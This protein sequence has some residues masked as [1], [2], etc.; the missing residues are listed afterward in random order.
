MHKL[1]DLILKQSYKDYEIII[2]D[3]GSDDNTLEIASNYPVKVLRIDPDDFSFGRSLNVGCEAAKGDYL[4]FISAHSYPTDNHWLAN[5]IKPFED[6]RIAMVYG[7]QIGDEIT[8][9]SEERDFKNNFGTKSKI[10]VEESFGNNANAAIRRS[11]WESVPF[12]EKLPALEDIDWAHKVQNKGFY[13][14]YKAD[15]VI[16]HIHAETYRQVYRRFRR[17]AI[18]YK[19]IFPDH[20]YNYAKAVLV[21][22]LM[23][24]MDVYYGLSRKKAMRKVFSPFIY[25]F[26]TL[27]ALH[28]GNCQVEKCDKGPKPG[29]A[30]PQKNL[31]VVVSDPGRHQLEEQEMPS[32]AADDVLIRVCY[33]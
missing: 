27:K 16:H 18:A 31:R 10:L 2:V 33:V 26:F 7:R 30:F 29:L 15:A 25:R 4:V 12:D 9:V 17:E 1:L 22:F 5:L 6:P 21:C 20:D 3:S 19:M 32:L 14:Y 8:K 11:L 23:V 28:D 13:V 24:I